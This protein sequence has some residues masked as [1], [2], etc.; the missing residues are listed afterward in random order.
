MRDV[1]S[2]RTALHRGCLASSPSS[3]LRGAP[4]WA[5]AECKNWGACLS[6]TTT[7]HQ[8]QAMRLHAPIHVPLCQC[9]K[10]A[11]SPWNK[12]P[13]HAACGL[14][15]AQQ[16]AAQQQAQMQARNGMGGQ[17]AFMN[18][19]PQP[20]VNAPQQGLQGQGRQIQMTQ[21]DQQR[22]QQIAQAM[23]HNMTPNDKAALSRHVQSMSAEVKQN[24]ESRGMNLLQYAIRQQATQKFMQERAMLAGQGGNQG[25]FP[26]GVVLPQSAPPAP[27]PV[28]VQGGQQTSQFDQTGNMDHIL[29]QQQDALRH[30]QEGQVVVPANTGQRA[31]NAP[32]MTRVPSSCTENTSTTSTSPVRWQPDASLKSKPS[33]A[34]ARLEQYAKADA[35]HT[36][37]PTNASANTRTEFHPHARTDPSAESIAGAEPSNTTAEPRDADSQPTYESTKPSSECTFTQTTTTN[38]KTRPTACPECSQRAAKAYVQWRTAP[39]S[40]SDCAAK[41]CDAACYAAPYGYLEN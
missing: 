13:P 27:T 35:E 12:S 37:D 15:G 10:G 32:N 36:A 19:Q 3:W 40:P 18:G 7:E 14:A 5:G 24:I 4:D 26:S 22:V 17:Q 28:M 38:S 31:A 8:E 34:A 1:D 2:T 41:G 33:A 29:G 16:Q 25:A 39:W 6:S 30:Q 9:R 23:V 11:A 21:Q 20:N